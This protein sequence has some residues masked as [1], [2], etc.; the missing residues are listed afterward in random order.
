VNQAAVG[1]GLIGCGTVGSGVVKLLLEERDL[2]ARRLGRPLELRRVLV[3][4]KDL[5]YKTQQVPPALLTT[6]PEQF[7]ATADMPI[8]VEL[9]GG[10]G[11]ISAMVRRALTLQKHV[12]TANKALLSVE[13]PELFALARQNQV[14]VSFEASCG[15]GIPC[16]TALH[17]GLMAN[18]I[19]GIYAI[20]NGT[21][22]YILTEMTQKQKSYA[23]ALKEAQEAGFA[24]ADPTLDVSGGDAAHKLA[25]VA[26]GAFGVQAVAGQVWC[27]GIDTLDLG[28]VRFGAELGYDIKSLAIAERSDAGL[29][30]RVHPCFLHRSQ[31]L[32]QVHGSFNA[33]SIFGHA[34]GHTMYYGRGAGM[35]PTASAV[36]SDILNVASGWYP[37]AFETLRLW[38]DQ[39]PAPT[40]V[41]PDDCRSRFY[42]RVN[43]K[44]QPGVMA[45]ITGILGAA[46]ISLSAV[47]QHEAG[48]GQFVPVVILTHQARQGSVLGALRQVQ[49]LD[50]VQG[51]PVRIRIVD[52]PQG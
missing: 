43:A 18:R 34:T 6:D 9:G 13:G 15:G 51:P 36:V 4:E 19:D 22:N 45:K 39:Q 40:L 27:E 14:T 31:L 30:L 52:I 46:G 48:A 11:A 26:S 8:L 32:A 41:S 25:I 10:R 44:D 38:S 50:V 28:D 42:L 2:Y 35:M 5:H 7:F 23:T 20:L 37:R 33:L 17:F 49:D 24:E 12:V 16:L 21:S 3:R 47:M 29:S 1:I